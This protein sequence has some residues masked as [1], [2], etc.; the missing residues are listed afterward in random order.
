MSPSLFYFLKKEELLTAIIEM[1]DHITPVLKDLHWLQVES[2][3][4]FKILLL[5]CKILNSQCPSY[6]F[7]HIY[8][9]AC[10]LRSSHCSLLKLPNVLFGKSNFEGKR[11]TVQVSGGSSYR[12]D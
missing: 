9:A 4:V 11:K 3:I 1:K 7:L 5:T 2:R 12:V 8:E 6:S 10:P